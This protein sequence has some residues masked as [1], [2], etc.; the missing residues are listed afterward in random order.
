MFETPPHGNE[1]GPE[2][3]KSD[4]AKNSALKH[5]KFI[6]IDDVKSGTQE[7]KFGLAVPQGSILHVGAVLFNLCVAGLYANLEA[8]CKC[9]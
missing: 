1:L 7:C 6:Q 4:Y 8:M 9:S 2:D 3:F 5:L